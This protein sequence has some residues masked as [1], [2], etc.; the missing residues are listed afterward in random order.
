MKIYKVL[1]I[2]NGEYIDCNT[3]VETIRK[4]AQLAVDRW[5][6][7]TQGQPYS[8]VEINEDG[9]ETWRNPEGQEIKSP[10]VLMAEVE[11]LIK[12]TLRKSKPTPVETL[13]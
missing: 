10:A 9:L 8:I 13:P 11:A 2:S 7:Y 3:E 1:N 4:I 5:F 6:E 12:S